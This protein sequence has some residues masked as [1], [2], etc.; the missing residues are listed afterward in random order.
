MASKLE[1]L[2]RKIEEMGGEDAFFDRLA[3]TDDLEEIARAYQTS[4]R[5]LDQWR[6]AND[7]RRAAWNESLEVS[8]HALAAEAK[9]ILDKLHDRHTPEPGGR[10]KERL[11]SSWVALAQARANQRMKLAAARN[12]G[13]Y[14]DRPQVTVNNSVNFAS[15]HLDALRARGSMHSPVSALALNAGGSA[16]GNEGGNGILGQETGRVEDP[17]GMGYDG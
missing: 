2:E 12:P 15:L 13:A 9:G 3:T 5:T 8:S 10:P 16:L 7:E 4:L 6:K 14:S 17:A 11:E 1:E